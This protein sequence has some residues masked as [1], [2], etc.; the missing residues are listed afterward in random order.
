LISVDKL[1]RL[2]WIHK[3]EIE[4]GVRKLFEWYRES[5]S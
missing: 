2:G 5:I 3:V 4:E 1:H